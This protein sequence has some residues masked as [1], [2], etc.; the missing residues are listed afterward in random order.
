MLS[1]R[2]TLVE[3][4]K[5]YEKDLAQKREQ[6]DNAKLDWPDTQAVRGQIAWI[7]TQINK[8]KDRLDIN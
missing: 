2:E 6:N 1:E 8:L 7:K 5:E 4:L 3:L